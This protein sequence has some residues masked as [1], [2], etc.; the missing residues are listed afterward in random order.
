[1]DQL[2]YADFIE[3]KTL[4]YKK[5]TSRKR[6]IKIQD[7]VTIHIQQTEEYNHSEDKSLEEINID[8]LQ[9]IESDEEE[10]SPL[11]KCQNCYDLFKFLGVLLFL[12]SLANALKYVYRK[13]FANN[14]LRIAFITILGARPLLL[15]LY[16][17]VITFSTGL[18]GS[19]SA[20]DD[21]NEKET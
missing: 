13:Q 14:E 4:P 8:E 10:I 20:N 15:F 3:A 19:V 21:E 18:T 7:H 12:I 2:N 6:P 1:M 9:S 11:Q 16:S 5:K 17:T